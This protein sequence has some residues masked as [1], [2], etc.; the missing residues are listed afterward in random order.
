MVSLT[1]DGKKVECREGTTVLEAVRSLGIKIPTLCYHE[2]LTPYGACRLCVVELISN[3]RKRIA[4]SCVY[5][6]EEGI[7]VVTDSPEIQK[8]RKATM[9][10]LLARSPDSSYLRERAKEMGI[11]EPRFV[12]DPEDRSDCILCG[13]CVRACAEI[14]GVAAIDFVERG[15]KSKVEPPFLKGSDVCIGCGTCVLVCPTGYIK[16]EHIAKVNAVH[17]WKSEEEA[18][19]CRVCG[20]YHLTP[21]YPKDYNRLFAQ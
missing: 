2:A 5:P 16:V 11:S 10:F 4:A 17:E 12:L 19:K 1:I 15:I 8:A 6:V 13:L 14:V 21:A 20:A 3:G 9:D 7:E 18:V